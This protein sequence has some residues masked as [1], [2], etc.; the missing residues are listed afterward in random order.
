MIFGIGRHSDRFANLEKLGPYVRVGF[1][2][3]CFDLIFVESAGGGV[4]EGSDS[5]GEKGG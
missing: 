1:G 5:G 4:V 2:R 3:P